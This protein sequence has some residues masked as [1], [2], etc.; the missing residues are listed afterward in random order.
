MLTT[1]NLISFL[2]EREGFKA[3]VYDDKQPWLDLNPGDEDVVKGV[4]TY[5]HGLTMDANGAPLKLGMKISLQ[6]SFDRVR[7]YVDAEVEPVLENLIHIDLT[8]EQYDALGSQ[9]Y[10]FGASEVSGWRLWGR[11]NR[12]ESGEL[13][14]M[15]WMDGTYHWDGQPTES[16]W[17]RRVAELLMF[18]G[19]DWR[20][21]ENLTWANNALSVLKTLGWDGETPKPGPAHTP[22][23]EDD[24]FDEPTPMEIAQHQSARAVG[25]EGDI[26]DFI[27]HRKKVPLTSVSKR[28]PIEAVDYIENP[29]PQVKRIEDS[30]RGKGY[31]KTTT[32]QVVGVAAAGGVV[33]EQI[34]AVE[35]VINFAEKYN[36]ATAATVFILLG[37]IALAWYFLGKWQRERG[38]DEATDLLG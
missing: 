9:V 25:Y 18:M 20:I 19:F 24:L 31:A 14:A 32:G 21:A 30:Q 17:K 33:A 11:I 4:L 2:A 7:A 27:K 1:A 13:I 3:K 38:E 5:G 6:D 12:Q 23:V 10:Q 34:G 29:E 37:F 28:V 22:S 35:P 16:I 26:E 15:E 8:G 36:M